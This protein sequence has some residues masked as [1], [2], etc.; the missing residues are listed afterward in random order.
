[1]ALTPSL[2]GTWKFLSGATKV[3]CTHES[4]P[5]SLSFAASGSIFSKKYFSSVSLTLSFNTGSNQLRGKLQ[6]GLWNKNQNNGEFGSVAAKQK[7]PWK[8]DENT[9]MPTIT[10]TKISQWWKQTPSP[11]AQIEKYSSESIITG[12]KYRQDMNEIQITMIHRIEWE[13]MELSAS[14]RT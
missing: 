10:T 1:M 3:I 7:T 6:V 14:T 13:I 5:F 8:R 12:Y 2:L 9:T 4:L 11:K